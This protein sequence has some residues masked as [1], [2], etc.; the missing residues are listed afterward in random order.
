MEQGE[1]APIP[2]QNGY[3][4]PHKRYCHRCHQ[5]SALIQPKEA[6][7]FLRVSLALQVLSA[8]CKR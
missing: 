7:R 5:L 2:L 8:P 4:L 6:D 3:F 1:G